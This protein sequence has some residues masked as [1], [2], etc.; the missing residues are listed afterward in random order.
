M[1]KALMIDQLDESTYKVLNFFYSYT[2]GNPLVFLEYV[3]FMHDYVS[4]DYRNPFGIE[5][6]QHY[7][8][9]NIKFL[10]EYEMTFSHGYQWCVTQNLLTELSNRAVAL[11]PKGLWTHH[12]LRRK[13]E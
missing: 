4:I 1:K 11:T 6:N 13:H 9:E 3:Y 10:K 12:L 2:Y 5:D 8:F 7:L